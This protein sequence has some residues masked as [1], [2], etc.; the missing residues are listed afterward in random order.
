MEAPVSHGCIA[1]SAEGRLDQ[2]E[3]S[4]GEL[5][6]TLLLFLQFLTRLTERFVLGVDM[7]LET[8]W[9]LWTE[10]L[11]VLGLDGRCRGCSFKARFNPGG[12]HGVTGTHSGWYVTHLSGG[13]GPS[14]PM[15]TGATRGSANVSAPRPTARSRG[16][17]SGIHI[18]LLQLSRKDLIQRV[19]CSRSH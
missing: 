3:D 14:E 7:F 9:K 4:V 6:M 11:D 18:K 1:P 10:I 19:R 15:F 13:S 2:E 16:G 12:S 5:V 8:L 17:F